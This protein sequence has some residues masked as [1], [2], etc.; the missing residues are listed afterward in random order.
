MLKGT[1]RASST[2]SCVAAG[3]GWPAVEAAL[4]GGLSP[5]PGF[6]AAGAGGAGGGREPPAALRVTRAAL[7]RAVCDR[8]PGRCVG[9]CVCVYVCM[10]VCV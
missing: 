3:R 2:A 8:D 9:V 10:C 6:G 7:V 4:N 5:P 1:K